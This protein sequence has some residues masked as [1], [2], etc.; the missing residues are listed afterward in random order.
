[1]L[2]VSLVNLWVHDQDV[3]LAFWTGKIGMELRGDVT[4]PEFGGLRWLTVGSVDQPDVELVLM[5]VPGPPVLAPA[6]TELIVATMTQGL[7]GAVFLTTDDVH[8]DFELFSSRG[9]EFTQ[10]P[11]RRAYGVDAGFR[12]PSGNQVRLTQVPS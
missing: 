6:Q 7:A 4:M 2:K 1:M 12:D 10:A 8:R 9:V 3:A 11:E 5:A